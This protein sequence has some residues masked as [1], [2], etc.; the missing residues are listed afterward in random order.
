MNWK[1]PMLLAVLLVLALPVLLVDA[2]IT[3]QNPTP[4]TGT[5]GGGCTYCSSE[6]CGCSNAPVGCQ[7]QSSCG[8]SSID[9][10]HTCDY[11]CR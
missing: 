11:Q 1:V 8:C 5:E 2:A 9:C 6:T 10:W 4:P 3:P 7:L